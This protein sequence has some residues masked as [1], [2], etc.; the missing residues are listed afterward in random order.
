MAG[1]GAGGTSAFNPCPAAGTPCIIMPLGD[2]ITY[3]VGSTTMGSYRAPLFQLAVTANQSITFVGRQT[4]GP[5]MV[6][7]RTFPRG[8][9]GYSGY[10]IDPDTVDGRS[11]I[12][13]LVDD[14]I[15]MFH[16]HIVL[17]M[18]GTNDVHLTY[19]LSAAPMRLQ[20]LIDKVTADAPNALVVVARLTPTQ[21]DTVNA[22]IQT[23]N[24]GIV[25]VVQS[26]VALGKHV[27]V[28]DMYTPFTSI[29]SYKAT[30]L[31]D[32]LHPNDAG[33]IVMAQVWY[34]AIQSY[35]RGP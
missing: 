6:A 14:A 5:T 21:D 2:S 22:N 33:Y 11:G 15:N 31:Y 9:E 16:P 13:P 10:T 18:I 30:L 7:G 23:Y 8:N 25:A 4:T 3:G 20:N 34:G 19:M 32:M 1:A 28:V 26:R 24:D 35:L 29:A 12:S 27:A 17:L